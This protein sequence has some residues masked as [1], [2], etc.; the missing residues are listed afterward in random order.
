MVN[1]PIGLSFPSEDY[2]LADVDDSYLYQNIAEAIKK[3]IISGELK[4]GNRLPSVRE[5]AVQWDCTAGT[6]QRAYQ[7]LN[8][9]GLVISRSGQGTRV[10]DRI[11]T[12]IGASAPLRKA[13]LVHRAESYLLEML[14]S[15]FALHE[16]EDA[17]RQ[18]MDR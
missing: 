5:M 18:A 16:I 10:A 15:G 9:Q 6:V 4:P 17:M 8:R 3:K 11:Q 13:A 7:E 14:T 12:A 1:Y 2:I